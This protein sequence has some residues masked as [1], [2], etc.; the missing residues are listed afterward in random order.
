MGVGVELEF[1]FGL[2]FRENGV[3]PKTA[4]ELGLGLL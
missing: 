4:L 1:H 3:E 2:S